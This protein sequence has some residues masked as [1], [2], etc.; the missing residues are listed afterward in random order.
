[1]NKKIANYVFLLSVVFNFAVPYSKIHA[2]ENT[3]HK[4]SQEGIQLAYNMHF[5]KSTEIFNT[6]ISMQPDNPYGYLLQSVNLYYR[7]QLEEN[8]SHFEEAFKQMAFNAMERSKKQLA[9]R[10]NKLD[11]LYYL[12][13]VHIYLAAYH[14]WE[15]N[16]IKAY[17]YGK[18][19]IE[20]LKRV[21][22]LDPE[23]HD[24]YLGLGLYHYYTDILPKVVKPLTFLL[25]IES[26]KQKGL[27]ELEVVAEHGSQ[28]RAEA[29]MFLGTINLY[30]ERDYQKSLEYLEKLVQLYPENTS[31]LMLLGENYQKIGDPKRAIQTLNY[32]VSNKSVNQFPVLAV[33]SY[34]RLGN[35]YYGLREFSLAITNYQIMLDLA[36]KSNQK[37][38]KVEW[39]KALANLNLGRT[40][41][42]MGERKTA[43]EYYGKVK[44]SDH[45]QAYKLAQERIEIPVKVSGDHASSKSFSEIMEMYQSAQI[46][47]VD[48]PK[49]QKHNMTEVMYHVAKA[50]YHK[51]VYDSAVSK[52]E[53]LV[54]SKNTT[55]AWIKPWSHFYLGSAYHE[56]GQSEKALKNLNLAA[57]Y[58]DQKLK[59]KISQKKNEIS[60]VSEQ[61]EVESRQ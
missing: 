57:Q 56:L 59:L 7:Y 40:Y 3:Y 44:K 18:D 47:A 33:S 29:L 38:G 41:D 8:S 25:G 13:T 4:L 34:F 14:G 17:I 53:K 5:D 60:F 31:F 28:S 51:G 45:K 49:A 55:S 21:I 50:F 20:Y 12:G 6:L 24:A 11:I 43:L 54:Q 10:S 52:F 19:G 2:S 23:Y 37:N 27:R 32:L 61:F 42:H 48:N 39:A 58:P 22:E 16:W 9:T 35:I 46:L 15:N 1:M 36:I 26:N 30:I